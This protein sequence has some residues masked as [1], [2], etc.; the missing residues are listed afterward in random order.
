MKLISDIKQYLIL[1]DFPSVNQAIADNSKMFLDLQVIFLTLSFV[2]LYHMFSVILVIWSAYLFGDVGECWRLN[3][4]FD[5]WNLLS[6]ILVFKTLL[7]ILI[8]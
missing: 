5:L 4:S 7:T 6:N 1:N 3:I 8:I 2:V